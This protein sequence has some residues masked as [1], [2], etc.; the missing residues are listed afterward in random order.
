[1]RPEDQ[2]RFSAVSTTLK[3]GREVVLRLLAVD[4]VE[5]LADFYDSLPRAT[6]RF[7]CPPR[8]TRDDAAMRAR[9]ANQTTFVCLVAEDGTTGHVVG[10]NWYQWKEEGSRISVF[11]I[12]LREAYRGVGLGRALMARLLEIAEEVGPPVM[13]L[14]V[15]LA[16]PRAVAL[17]QKMG[18]R[19]VR[20][21]EREKVAD[22]E[23]EPEYYME[24][25]IRDQETN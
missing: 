2:P 18:F 21:Q 1:M 10:Y 13:S 14:T 17:Y 8:L 7:Y 24:Q 16:N 15:Q 23:A 22:F 12:C 9:W 5:A 25:S 3:D 4:D 6:W 11:G 20:E 19:I